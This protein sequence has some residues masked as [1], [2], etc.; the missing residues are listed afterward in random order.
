MRVHFDEEFDGPNALPKIHVT[1]P[2]HWDPACTNSSSPMI[3]TGSLILTCGGPCT[4]VWSDRGEYLLRTGPEV[5]PH[6][7]MNPLPTPAGA[8]TAVTDHPGRVSL[9][10][11]FLLFRW[12]ATSSGPPSCPSLPERT[13]VFSVPTLCPALWTIP[14]EFYIHGQCLHTRWLA[15]SAISIHTSIA[16]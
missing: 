4:H 7:L 6:P 13:P 16:A 15:L 11:T 3:P 1:S 10:L 5:D 14:D 9:M 2:V 12:S 8:S